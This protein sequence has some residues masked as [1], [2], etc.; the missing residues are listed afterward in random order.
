MKINKDPFIFTHD[1][2]R[3][4]LIANGNVRIDDNRWQIA[5]TD[6]VM[7]R[8]VAFKMLLRDKNLG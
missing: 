5:G 7:S 2:I 1:M 4:A 6:Q 3:A 8:D